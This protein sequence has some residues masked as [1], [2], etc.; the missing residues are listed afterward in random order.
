[1][2]GHALQLAHFGSYIKKI[3]SYVALWNVKSLSYAGRIELIKGV[4]QG[5]HAFWLAILPIPV[6]V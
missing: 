6:N 2:A 3:S 5:V 4:L 1:M